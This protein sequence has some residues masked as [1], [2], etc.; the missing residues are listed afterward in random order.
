M[1]YQHSL[2][3]RATGKTAFLTCERRVI[4]R[5]PEVATRPAPAWVA[6]SGGRFN[7]TGRGAACRF[8]ASRA[9]YFAWWTLFNATRRVHWI[10]LGFAPSRVGF[11]STKRTP[12]LHGVTNTVARPSAAPRRPVRA[13][14]RRPAPPGPSD[15]LLATRVRGCSRA[16]R[17]TIARDA[18]QQHAAEEQVRLHDD[19][20][21][22]PFGDFVQALGPAVDRPSRETRCGPAA[23]SS[24]AAAT[25]RNQT[26]RRVAS[27]SWL[28][29]P[30]NDQRRVFG[31]DLRV[32]GGRLV[33]NAPATARQIA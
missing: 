1:Q 11:V 24:V 28:P 21:A 23:G 8:V 31:R 22:R 25:E 33:R 30:T 10:P 9:T 16:N 26:S 5:A 19:A 15:R 17:S 18:I 3:N 20:L 14:R 13:R 27:A 32:A 2:P 6:P 4:G 12:T 29:R 7:N